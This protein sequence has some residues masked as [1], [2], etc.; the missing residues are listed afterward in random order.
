MQSSQAIADDATILALSEAG[1]SSRQIEAIIGNI[2]HSTICNRLK[3]LTPRKS[4]EIYKTHRADILA[5]F[6]RKC[7]STLDVKAIK[8]MCPRDRVLAM[9]LAYDKERVERGLSDNNTRP[10]V[11]IQVKGDAQIAVDNSVK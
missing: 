11:V 9:G 3:H 6:Q 8:E 2:D 1:K 5:E 4:T 7:M 10:M